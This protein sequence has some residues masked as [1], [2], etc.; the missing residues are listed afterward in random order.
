MLR[1]NKRYQFTHFNEELWLNLDGQVYA[2]TSADSMRKES[3]GGILPNS[4]SDDTVIELSA[5]A[6]KAAGRKY[7]QGNIIRTLCQNAI[8][9]LAVFWLGSALLYTLQKQTP[10]PNA[11]SAS[12]ATF[13]VQP[14]ELGNPIYTTPAKPLKPQHEFG[15]N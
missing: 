6:M 7:P 13:P 15:Y 12:T 3:S 2:I 8:L 11:C 1:K 5:A 4:L 14:T 10:P 9:L